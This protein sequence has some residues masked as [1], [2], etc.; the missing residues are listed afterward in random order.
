MFWN[1]LSFLFWGPK[2]WTQAPLIP[3]PWR[4][5]DSPPCQAHSA[6]ALPAFCKPNFHLQNPKVTPK[7]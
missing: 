6:H 5:G 2:T 1:L 3:G 4:E 7:H